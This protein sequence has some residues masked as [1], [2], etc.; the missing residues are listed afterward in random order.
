MWV[1]ITTVGVCG[2]ITSEQICSLSLKS[3]KLVHQCN[4]SAYGTSM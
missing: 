3:L 4:H 2:M 1:A